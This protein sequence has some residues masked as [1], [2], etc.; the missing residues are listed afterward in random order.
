MS[1]KRRKKLIGRNALHQI[2][3]WRKLGVPMTVIHKRLGLNAF[4]SLTATNNIVIPD[5]EGLH[6]S[7][8]PT[9]LQDEP[10][11]QEAPHNIVYEGP[12]PNGVWV[13]R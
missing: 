7:T 10:L 11:I 9:W 12:F 3:E 6:S 5:E 4:Q 2:C 13:W 1:N 8:R